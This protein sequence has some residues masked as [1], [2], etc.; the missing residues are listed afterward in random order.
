M[1]TKHQRCGRISILGGAQ[2]WIQ[3]RQTIYNWTC[4]E[5][6]FMITDLWGSLTT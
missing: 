3:S 1:G 5:Q 4:F 6:G 2:D